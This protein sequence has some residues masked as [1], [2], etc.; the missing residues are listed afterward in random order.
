MA[1][2]FAVLNQNLIINR[3]EYTYRRATRY[4]D[5]INQV[6]SIFW[7]FHSTSPTYVAAI[8]CLAINSCSKLEH[9]NIFIFTNA[10]IGVPSQYLILEE[11]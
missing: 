8:A 10:N 1:L 5:E 2:T 7:V 4:I 9:V 3:R 11:K 6:S